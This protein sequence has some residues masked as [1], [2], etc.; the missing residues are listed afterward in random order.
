[1]VSVGFIAA[2][3]IAGLN[4]FVRPTRSRRLDGIG[5]MSESEFA[6]LSRPMA[7]SP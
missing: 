1:M 6:V 7:I 5:A 4:H 3:A 2:L